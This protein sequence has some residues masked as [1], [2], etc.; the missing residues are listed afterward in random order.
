M[1]KAVAQAI[2]TNVR[3][4][5]AVGRFGGEEFVVLL[6]EVTEAQTRVVGERIRH[7]IHRLRVPI[8]LDGRTIEI[9]GLSASIGIALYPDH[10]TG[11]DKLVHKADTAMYLAKELGRNMVVVSLA[12]SA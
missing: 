12:N 5:D 7:A 11:L 6:T 9:R 2:T 3:D 8:T 1:L 4:L 10:A